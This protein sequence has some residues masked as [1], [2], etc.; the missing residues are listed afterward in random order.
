MKS[1]VVSLS[2]G[3]DSTAMLLQMLER[4]ENIVDIVFFDTGWE[5]A[6]M[7]EHLDQL[8][9]FIGRKITRLTPRVPFDYW[10]AEHKVYHRNGDYRRTGLG[11][12]SPS[13]RW[14]T[15]EKTRAIHT[16]CNALTWQGYGVPIVQCIGFAADEA[17]RQEEHYAKNKIAYQ[18]FRYPLI[19]YGM[20][21][22]DCLAYCKARGFHWGG[23][24]NVFS[25]VSCFCCPLQSIENLRDTRILFPELWARMLEMEAMLP[26]GDKGRGY[27]D[28]T[29]LSDFEKRFAADA[30]FEARRCILPGLVI[31]KKQLEPS[32]HAQG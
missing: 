15:K 22:A 6:Q 29:T 3:K 28:R 16:Y 23:L 2:G 31:P 7:H 18:D 26:E 9:A 10:F 21:E 11:W 8:E 1:N 12:P 5:Y 27:K 4:G 19:E 13:R 32:P 20:T 25:R 14:C 30:D 24:Y 17:N